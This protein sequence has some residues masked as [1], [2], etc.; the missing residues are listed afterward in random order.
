MEI[1]AKVVACIITVTI[2]YATGI[3]STPQV[4]VSSHSHLPLQLCIRDSSVGDTRLKTHVR[5]KEGKLRGF[6][7][8]ETCFDGSYTF[9]LDCMDN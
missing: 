9:P 4:E 5:V 3:W 1:V 2:I 7:Q 6:Y 8:M